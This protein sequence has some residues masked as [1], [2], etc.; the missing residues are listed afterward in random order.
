MEF[1]KCLA[2]IFTE[3]LTT[4]VWC[5]ISEGAVGPVVGKIAFG[6]TY[7]DTLIEKRLG[8]LTRRLQGTPSQNIMI[9]GFLR[10]V[11]SLNAL[12]PKRTFSYVWWYCR[13]VVGTYVSGVT[14]QS[15]EFKDRY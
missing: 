10:P 11:C 1:R 6:W 12:F 9:D 5:F 2:S 3:E 4:K 15:N 7:M 8:H 13:I 14:C